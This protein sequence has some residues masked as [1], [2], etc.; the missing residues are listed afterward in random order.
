[1]PNDAIASD[2][3]EWSIM[4]VKVIPFFSEITPEERVN[5]LM[6]KLSDVHADVTIP[7]EHKTP[8]NKHSF[9]FVGSGGTERAMAD[10]IQANEVKD[11]IILLAHE[12]GNSLPAAMETRA[13]LQKEGHV[14]RVIHAPLEDILKLIQQ[15]NEFVEIENQI[16]NS[17]LG[18]FG[19]PSSWLIASNVD[20]VKVKER[21]GVTILQ[22]PLTDVTGKLENELTEEGM[23]RV[24]DFVKSAIGVEVPIEDI[25]DAG[26]ITQ[27]MVQ[28]VTENKLDAVTLQC[29]AL[30]EQTEVTGCFALSHLNDVD[31]LVAGCEGDIPSTFTLM[32]AKLFTKEAAFMAN[33]VEADEQKN[34]VV[35]AHCTTPTDILAN[36]DIT[37]HFETGQSVAVRGEFDEQPVTVLKVFGED[38]TDYWVSGGIIVENNVDECGCRTQIRVRLDEPVRYFLDESLANH[39][40]ILMG[41][42]SKILEDFFSFV[43][44]EN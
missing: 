44:G 41:N 7:L 36:Y 33:V 29:F 26:K 12:T 10:F 32:V 11:P 25:Q 9:I 19:E 14:A 39:H 16:R 37:T 30:F 4:P 5:G 42:Y 43:L 27:S 24:E 22:F 35:F 17:R 2:E 20:P 34:T 6:S 31:G 13:Y 18:I 3:Y 40:V 1:M 21:W 15:W 8:L 38:L 23:E 28:L